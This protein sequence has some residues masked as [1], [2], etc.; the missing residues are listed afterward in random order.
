MKVHREVWT[1]SN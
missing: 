1:S